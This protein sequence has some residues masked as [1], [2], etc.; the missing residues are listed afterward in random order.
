MTTTFIGACADHRR[1]EN[2]EEDPMSTLP[3]TCMHASTWVRLKAARLG[4]GD[5]LALAFQ[6]ALAFPLGDPREDCQ[7]EATRRAFRIDD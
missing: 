5:A 3:A 6:H 4:F 1:A 2:N 7:D